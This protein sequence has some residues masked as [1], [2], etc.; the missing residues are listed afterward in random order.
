MGGSSLHSCYAAKEPT[1]GRGRTLVAVLKA[2]P[3]PTAPSAHGRHTRQRSTKWGVSWPQGEPLPAVTLL[4]VVQ[5]TQP[6]LF[7]TRQ[8]D[9]RRRTARVD[10][11]PHCR[12]VSWLA[13]GRIGDLGWLG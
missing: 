2:S 5:S 3:C 6:A 11:P 1:T 13:I 4:S 7:T 8:P 12:L 10:K 9:A